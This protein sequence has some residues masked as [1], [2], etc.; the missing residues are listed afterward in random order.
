VGQVSLLYSIVGVAGLGHQEGLCD[1]RGCLADLL[2]G[3]EAAPWSIKTY[4]PPATAGAR[5]DCKPGY[6]SMKLPGAASNMALCSGV[7]N[8]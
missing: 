6:A 4:Q 3:P 7:Q 1:V 5:P 2:R 8:Q